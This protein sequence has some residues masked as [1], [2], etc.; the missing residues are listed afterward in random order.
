MRGLSQFKNVKKRAG[1][2]LGV[3]AILAVCSGCDQTSGVGDG[4]GSFLA[5][6]GRQ[7]LA[8]LVL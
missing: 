1:L 3:A 8:A 2:V 4:L 5:D 6:F 7:V